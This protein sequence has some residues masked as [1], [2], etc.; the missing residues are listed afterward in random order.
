MHGNDHIEPDHKGPARVQ[1]LRRLD[2]CAVSDALDR[3]RLLGVV[4]GLQ[5]RAG[6]QRIAGRVVTV[7]LGVGDPVEGQ[8]RH[9][10][11]RAI[12][13]AGP[14]DV[15]VVEQ[16]TGID[17]AG[18]GGLL[19]LG[20]QLRGIAA[21][22]VDGPIRDV[23]ETAA[24]GFTV[25]SRSVTS[26]TARG[27]LIEVGTNVPVLVG[28]LQVN[29]GDYLVA[30]GSAVVVVC[31]R[32]IDGVLDAAEAIMAKEAAFASA[33]LSGVSIACVMDGAYENMLRE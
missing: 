28:T 12:G 6:A 21:A 30:D 10:C 3:L 1:R 29:A 18:W 26:R 5:R 9:L 8:P 33:I 7:K 4:T 25:F 22:I 19:S 11:C 23:D 2:C 24:L 32:D 27:R 15:I 16:R 17:G 20:A 31:A 13:S 14:N